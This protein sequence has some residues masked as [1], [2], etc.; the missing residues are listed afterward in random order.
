MK[1]AAAMLFTMMTRKGYAADRE[2][3][4]LHLRSIY[5][6]LDNHFLRESIAKSYEAGLLACSLVCAFSGVI[7]Q[8]HLAYA[9]SRTHTIPF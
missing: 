7:T 9:F 6:Q 1:N 2:K 3:R 8:W 5:N 4:S